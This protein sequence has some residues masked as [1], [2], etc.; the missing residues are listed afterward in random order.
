[1]ITLGGQ[2]PDGTPVMVVGLDADDLA[3]L[4]AGGMIKFDPAAMS[5]NGMPAIGIVLIPGRT[6]GDILDRLRAAGVPAP[7]PPSTVPR[8]TCEHQASNFTP[9]RI[10]P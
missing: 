4:A 1:M 2:H 7:A 10:C 3:G 9:C 6:E 8:Y 5:A